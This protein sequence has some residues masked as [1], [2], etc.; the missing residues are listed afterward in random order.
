MS[1][2]I[3]S[4]VVPTISDFHHEVQLGGRT[5]LVPYDIELHRRADRGSFKACLLQQ[6]ARHAIQDR[7]AAFT[8]PAWRLPVVR[9][10]TFVRGSLDEEDAWRRTAASKDDGACS[11]AGET[12]SGLIIG[13]ADV[14]GLSVGLNSIFSRR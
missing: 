8:P 7:A 9:K 14:E 10:E 5:L 11:D 13:G 4:E 1:G 6:L 2:P 12:A 3:E